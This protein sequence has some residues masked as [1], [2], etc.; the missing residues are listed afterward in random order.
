MAVGVFWTRVGTPTAESESGTAE[1][2]VR[3]GDAGKPVMLLGSR[4]YMATGAQSQRSGSNDDD[5]LSAGL[6]G[7]HHAM[8][9]PYLLEGEHP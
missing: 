8:R 3:V 2:M 7:L 5:H 4:C 1:E 6:V 9:F